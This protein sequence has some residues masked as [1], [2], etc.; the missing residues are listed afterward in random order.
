VLKGC[1]PTPIPSNSTDLLV[2]QRLFF[3]Q[4][5]FRRQSNRDSLLSKKYAPD[6]LKDKTEDKLKWCRAGEQAEQSFLDRGDH[7]LS[8]RLNPEKETSP[9]PHDFLLELPCDLKTITTP[10]RMAQEF[11]GIDPKYAVSINEK[12]LRRYSAKCPLMMLILDISHELYRGIHLAMLDDLVYFANEGIAKRHEYWKRIHDT[13]GNAKASY[14]Y[15]CQWFPEARGRR[16]L[17]LKK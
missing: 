6:V 2:G 13:Q 3:T 14:I 9:F 7:G 5:N 8:V 4:L 16:A 12:D 10:F 15:D 1:E 17:E 11:F